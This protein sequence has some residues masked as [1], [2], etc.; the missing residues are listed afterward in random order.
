MVSRSTKVPVSGL[1]HRRRV[2]ALAA[3]LTARGHDCQMFSLA[4]VAPA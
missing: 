1:G 2:E 4:E 3:E